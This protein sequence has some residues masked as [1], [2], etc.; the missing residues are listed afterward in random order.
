MKQTIVCSKDDWPNVIDAIGS[1]STS[2]PFRFQGKDFVKVEREVPFYPKVVDLGMRF[3]NPDILRA[4]PI[5]SMFYHRG[6]VKLIT[7]T[8]IGVKYVVDPETK[9]GSR[10]DAFASHMPLDGPAH[11]LSFPKEATY[12]HF[13]G[14]L[15]V[16]VVG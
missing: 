4:A 3:N 11:F 6:Q 16:E 15:N 12:I 9:L 1:N 7:S 5:G 2:E 13:N 10:L 14:P 8:S